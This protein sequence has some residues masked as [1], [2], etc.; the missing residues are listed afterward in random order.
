M[1]MK[2]RDMPAARAGC[3]DGAVN[4]TS[5]VPPLGINLGKSSMTLQEAIAQQPQWIGWW[6]NWMLF[7]A[8]LLPFALLFWRQ[9]RIAGIATILAS[10]G[11]AFGVNWLFAQLGYV[12][13]LGLPHIL[14]WTPVAIYLAVL[15]R[16]PDTPVWPRRIMLVVLATIVVSLAFDYTDVARYV[17]GERT[18]TIPPPTA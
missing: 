16:H 7:G 12:K 15:I 8:F 13:L 2:H 4:D 1:L 17:L 18:P 10:V 11:G 6:L 9:T 3:R 14:L 5:A